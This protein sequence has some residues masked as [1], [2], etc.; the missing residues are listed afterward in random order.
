M[1]GIAMLLVALGHCLAIAILDPTWSPPAPWPFFQAGHAGVMLFFMLSGYVIGLT[2]PEPFSANAAKDYLSR[3][4]LRILP[5][6]IIAWF[7]SALVSSGES[8]RAIIGNLFFLQNL[9]PYFSTTLLPI[10][11]NGPL[12]SLHYEVMYYLLFLALWRYRPPFWLHFTGALALG[13]MGWFVPGFP[14][15]IAGY[16]CGWLFWGTGWWLS[17]QPR[18]ASAA[19][20]AGPLLSGIFLLMA[21]H[22]FACGRIFLN[23]LGFKRDYAGL[24][25]LS[26]VS[27][28]PSALLIMAAASRRKLPGAGLVKIAAF[29]Q[30]IGTVVLLL[31]LGRL[32][33]SLQWL[34]ATG[35]GAVACVF[36]GFRRIDWLKIFAP[37]GKISYAF[38]II[39]FPMLFVVQRLPLPHGSCAG[40]LLRLATWLILTIGAASLLEL[41][42]QVRIKN[43][44]L[45]HR[46]T[47]AR[48]MTV[49]EPA[50]S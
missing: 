16:G 41:V 10:K 46:P 21:T 4:A 6:Y 31:L 29:G 22:H 20:P 28:L 3:R 49:P 2:D 48:P 12:W 40:Y 39:H 30:V 26:N 13:A 11:A 45:R 34:I 5:I 23:G 1:R 33:D 18:L 27:L 25:N 15:F 38:Y 9:D 32:G 36:A 50:S 14:F 42:F 37:L 8:V 17:R 44:W 24:V 19:E 47:A 7:F 35:Y 43:W